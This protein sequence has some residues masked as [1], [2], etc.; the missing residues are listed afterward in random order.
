MYRLIEVPIVIEVLVVK[1]IFARERKWPLLACLVDT[2][3]A[4]VSIAIVII[5]NIQ[6]GQS[7]SVTQHS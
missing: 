1:A 4:A 6:A 2:L 3:T 5:V 7:N